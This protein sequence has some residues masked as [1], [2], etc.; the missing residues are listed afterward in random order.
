MPELMIGIQLASLRQP[1]K[2]ALLTAAQLGANAV[3]IDARNQLRP[4]ELTQTGVR[5]LRKMLEDLGLR[6]C[7]IAFSTRRGYSDPDDLDRRVEATKDAMSMAYKLGAP[8][9]IN[10]IGQ[11]PGEAE[12]P[13]WETLC[14]VLS[15]LGN[16]G[17][18][19]GAFFAAET[20]TED[21]ET[22]DRLLNQL[23]EGSIG[24]NFDPGNLI[25]NGFS[26]SAA[27]SVLG[28]RVMHVH[29]KDAVRDLAQGRGIETPLGRGSVDFQELIGVLEN[30]GYRGAFTI[31]RQNSTDPV[32][33][34]GHAVRYLR[35]L[36]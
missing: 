15:D 30:H 35:S 12:G 34:I 14:Q 4:S 19:A 31:E 29:A 33:E 9:V 28:R 5:Q 36:V 27:I 23:P 6:V 3:E 24:V 26:A 22:L 7:A 11:V 16:Y 13:E 10:Q 32:D 1:F 18:R 8:C 17:Q 25:I 21:G 20:G 2:K